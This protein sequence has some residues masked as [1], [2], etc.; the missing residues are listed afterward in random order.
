[1]ILLDTNFILALFNTNDT[2]HTRAKKDSEK[3]ALENEI[4][5]VPSLVVVELISVANIR[6]KSEHKERLCAFIR[7]LING[8][9]DG[10]IFM[11]HSQKEFYESLHLSMLPEN[12]DLSFVDILLTRLAARYKVCN[13]LTYD[14]KLLTH[15]QYGTKT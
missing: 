6:L 2:L 13:I 5:V 7:S 4:F 10:F 1:M 11:E 9:L 15:I 3:Y 12:T 8:T 14:K